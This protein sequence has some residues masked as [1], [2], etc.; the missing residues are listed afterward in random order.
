MTSVIAFFILICVLVFVHE[1]GHFWAAR[2]CGVKVIRFSIGFGKV[3]FKKT[4]KH[5]TEFAFSLI[6]LG[7]YVQMYNGENEHQAR[8]DQTLASKS[9]LQRA[10]IIVAG[11]LANFIFAIL[12]YWLVF[13]NGIPTLKP[14]TGQILPDTIAAQAKLPTEFEIKRVASHNVQDWEE[15]T[16]ALI[17]YVGSDRVEVEGSLVG[18]DRLQRFYLDLS[19]WNVDGNKENPLTTL[20]IRTKSS[21]V[22]PE[23]KQVIENSPAAKAGLQAG[24]KI[25]S[26]NQTP[27]D[28]ADLVKQ[29]QTGQILELTVEKSGNTYRYS[30]QPDKK[31]DRYFIGIVPSYEP[32]AD[33][34]RTELKYDI[35]TALWKSVEKVGALVKTILQFIGNL[36]TGELSLKNMGG[37]ISMA[38]GAGATAE[39]GW[40]YYISFMA[41]ISVN[42]GVM[43]LFPILPL[44]GGQLILLGAETV[45][46]KPLA[47]K[48][49]LRFQ[50]IGV[51]FVL[52]LMAF[53][54]MN[55]LIHF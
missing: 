23:I 31:D 1:Y 47:E 37:P 30:L 20:G 46:G 5:G 11:P 54:F 18:E 7:G 53:A 32:L 35:L 24:D 4:D 25:V 38:K 50:Q 52:S 55:D 15:T 40:V 21:I 8:A 10:F 14:V 36:I 16:L 28:W 34:Y 27:F 6:P 39:I 44:D 3:L 12:A 22:K 45:R 17:G 43:N 33:K 51:F 2:K 42:L 41:L 29:V 9:A 19:N 13:A 49:Q 26:V 48:F